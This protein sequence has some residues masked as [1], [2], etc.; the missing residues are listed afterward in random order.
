MT[1]HEL[2][3]YA[4][5]RSGFAVLDEAERGER[6]AEIEALWERTPELADGSHAEVRWVTRARR[7]R[8]LI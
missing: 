1:L 3:D 8:G 7:Y 5:S 2:Q 6:L 4:S